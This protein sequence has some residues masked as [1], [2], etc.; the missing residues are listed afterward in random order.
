[1]DLSSFHVR[2]DECL[3]DIILCIVILF[4]LS[5]DCKYTDQTL[6][7]QT[8][9]RQWYRCLPFLIWSNWR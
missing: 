1:V 3:I 9:G 2:L 8:E 7:R 4:S 6:F 5:Q